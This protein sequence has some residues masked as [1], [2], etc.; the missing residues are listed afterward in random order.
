M[1]SVLIVDDAAVI[2]DAVCLMLEDTDFTCQ[3]A[4]NG[5]AALRQLQSSSQRLIV[6]LDWM[7]PG[8]SGQEL[9][10][11]VAADPRLVGRHAIILMTAAH[12]LL[13]AEFQQRLN[14]LGVP[15]LGKP[16]TIEQLFAVVSQAA[17]RLAASDGDHHGDRHGVSVARER[18]R[19][20]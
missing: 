20:G 16:F 7:L 9:L 10:E 13:P 18:D 5:E 17:E 14:Q 3:Q 6:L 2:R 12:G 11:A 1:P 4:A 15:V 19:A 8:L